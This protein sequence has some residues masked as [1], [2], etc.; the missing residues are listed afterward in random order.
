ML[1][2]QSACLFFP[3]IFV[4]FFSTLHM[5]ESVLGQNSVLKGNLL[6]EVSFGRQMT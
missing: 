1:G 5:V 3:V 2:R 6:G 4:W